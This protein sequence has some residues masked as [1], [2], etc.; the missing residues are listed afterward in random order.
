MYQLIDLVVN[1]DD[2]KVMFCKSAYVYN[3]RLLETT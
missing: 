1:I 2:V 3:N